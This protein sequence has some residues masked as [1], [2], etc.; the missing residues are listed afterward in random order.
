MHKN[1]FPTADV[2]NINAIVR[3]TLRH[4]DLD[5]SM[6]SFTNLTSNKD[7]ERCEL[8]QIC[9]DE[10]LDQKDILNEGMAHS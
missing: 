5:G 9:P 8:C 7:G 4:N 10:P 1:V 3:S 6:L 2:D